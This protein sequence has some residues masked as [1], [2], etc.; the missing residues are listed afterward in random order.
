MRKF[1]AGHTVS[2]VVRVASWKFLPLAPNNKRWLVWQIK[3]SSAWPANPFRTI[4]PDLRPF[5]STRIVVHPTRKTFVIIPPLEKAIVAAIRKIIN[6]R[7][8][9]VNMRD[10]TFLLSFGKR[11][12]YIF[13]IAYKILSA[14]RTQEKRQKTRGPGTEKNGG[15]VSALL[16][17]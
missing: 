16:Q 10:K 7:R 17:P 2:I 5:L 4:G 11:I 6:K 8:N 3:S 15:K 13:K 12:I 14:S 9:W 1:M